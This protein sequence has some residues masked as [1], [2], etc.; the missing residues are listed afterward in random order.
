ML[1]FC[2]TPAS[3]C[4]RSLVPRPSE[5]ALTRER[6]P[7]PRATRRTRPS[8]RVAPGSRV[9]F[10]RASARAHSPGTRESIIA[11][12]RTYY[13]FS[14][15]ARTRSLSRAPA[16]RAP[17]C[18]SGTQNSRASAS[19]GPGPHG[20]LS[21]IRIREVGAPGSRVSF[22]RA[23]ARASLRPGHAKSNALLT[24]SRFPPGRSPRSTW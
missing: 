6:E 24:A 15:S 7:G 10:A 19:R 3:A 12:A 13:R 20:S 17:G 11:P 4:R 23:S 22:A 21:A 5:R 2:S 18:R 14:I 9:S 16:K 8:G 1:P